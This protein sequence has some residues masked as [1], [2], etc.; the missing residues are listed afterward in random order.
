MTGMCMIEFC[1]KYNV[2]PL[3]IGARLRYRTFVDNDT[4]GNVNSRMGPR[5]AGWK[6]DPLYKNQKF[7]LMPEHPDYEEARKPIYER[8]IK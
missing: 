6:D 5:T 4:L 8:G 1:Q 2:A 7:W 3:T